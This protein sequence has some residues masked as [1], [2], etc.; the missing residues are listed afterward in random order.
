[1]IK[2]IAGVSRIR[3]L[4]VFILCVSGIFSGGCLQEN[5][6]MFGDRPLTEIIDA[7]T[8]EQKVNIVVGGVRGADNP[9]FPAPGMPVRNSTGLTANLTS[10][11]VKGAA[12]YGYAIDSLG[13]PV[14]TYA[15]GPAGLRIDPFREGDSLT[16]FCTAFPTGSCLAASWD[17]SSVRNVAAAIGNEAKEYGVD[18]LLA[19][20]INIIRNPLCGRNFEYYSEDPLLTGLIAEA[21][22]KGVQSNNV[23]VS[24]KHFAVN[25][26]ETL[27]NGINVHVSE[28]AMREIYFKAF[29]HIVREAGPWTIMSSYNKINGI[30]ASE[31]EW[32]LTDVLRDD[33][34]YDGVVVTDWWA[35]ENGARQQAAG[36]DLLMPGSQ[37]QYDEI[38]SAIINGSLPEEILDRSVSR[39]LEL[40][41]RTNAF[42]GYEYSSRP[43]LDGHAVI[44][45][46]AGARGMVLLENDGVL[47]LSAGQRLALFGNAAYDTFVG[48]TGSGNVNRRYKV[49]IREGFSDAGYLLCETLSAAYMKYIEEE[50]ARMGGENFWWVPEIEE[51]AVT[52]QQVDHYVR[53]SDVAVYVLGRMAGEGEDREL[54][55]GD[56]YLGSR[57]LSLMKNIVDTAH[58]QGKKA[59]L[60]LNM[61]GMVDLENCPEFDAVLH[62]WMPGQEAGHAV[63]DVV[64]GRVTPSGKLPFTWARNYSDY[65]SSSDF[66]LSDG[67][68]RDVS[69]RD[70]IFV[71]YRGFDKTGTDVR[72]PFG[73][74]LSYTEFTYDKMRVRKKKSGI[75]VC[76]TVSNSG[77]CPGR[78]VVQ[79]YTSPVNPS[80]D[81]PVKELRAFSLT[82][83][84]QPGES[85]EVRMRFDKNDM[86]VWE[87]G[88]WMMKH[89]KYEILAASS[90]EDIRLRSPL[91]L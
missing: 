4:T 9:P 40:T 11:K 6:K 72:Y 18:I 86:S 82:P 64:S 13:L 55:K 62:A 71:G 65:L 73:Y 81:R 70:D 22:V 90:A 69:Y 67:S 39:I 59:V 36:N 89:G 57:E 23:G 24:V 42:S 37:H 53:L 31:N 54:A 15:D 68:D 44:A 51:M 43:N 58:D 50:K 49:N 14:V 79:L 38:M 47:P 74:G 52:P 60:I 2:N 84:L 29:E 61:G 1:M 16:Y 45:R 8:L 7:L 27:R 33:W 5:D 30:L 48:G 91:P 41:S 3:L 25:N 63:A 17:T 28:R 76:L 66:P 56:Y 77:T 35:E 19:P 20:G 78:E 34:G 80:A 10:G 83:V 88:R 85:C 12:A 87:N 46:D 75:N 21:Y 26:Q 32:L